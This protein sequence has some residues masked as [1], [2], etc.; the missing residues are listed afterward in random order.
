M[1]CYGMVWDGLVLVRLRW[2]S[3]IPSAT[4]LH[5]QENPHPSLR[6][7]K[8]QVAYK[9]CWKLTVQTSSFGLP[10][11]SLTSLS[12]EI[13]LILIPQV[14][15]LVLLRYLWLG[16]CYNPSPIVCSCRV[17]FFLSLVL[18]FALSPDQ[19]IRPVGVS[20]EVLGCRKNWLR[21]LIAQYAAGS[22]RN[23]EKNKLS[24]WEHIWYIKP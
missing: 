5:S 16:F 11:P 20:Q 19:S 8:L 14:N 15:R 4:V 1:G 13:V 24:R 7:S 17:P 9:L 21:L 12:L 23:T 3:P 18:W 10:L 6:L 2:I 22:V